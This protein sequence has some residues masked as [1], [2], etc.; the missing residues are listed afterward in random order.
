MTWT[1]GNPQRESPDLCRAGILACGKRDRRAPHTAR[2]RKPRHW[3][4]RKDRF[5]GA[6][7]DAP[8]WLEDGPD[9][10]A[11]VLLDRLSSLL[12][13]R[14]GVVNRRTLQPGVKVGG[15]SRSTSCSKPSCMNPLLTWMLR[16]IWE[17]LEQQPKGNVPVAASG[18][19]IGRQ[20]QLSSITLPRRESLCAGQLRFLVRR[21][22][23]VGQ[24]YIGGIVVCLRLGQ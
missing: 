17:Q 11:N 23:E 21:W 1:R 18:E 5:G 20:N 6:W 10:T 3:R 15:A 4:T 12:P 24:S 7:P 2:V 19:A 16:L 14:F 9:T 22:R 8:G 13:R